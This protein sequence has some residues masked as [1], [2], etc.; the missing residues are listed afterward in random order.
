MHGKLESAWSLWILKRPGLLVWPGEEKLQGSPESLMNGQALFPSVTG[1][2]CFL[3]QP[4][5]RKLP[6]TRNHPVKRVGTHCEC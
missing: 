3:G 1:L 2:I 5:W 4:V 6:G